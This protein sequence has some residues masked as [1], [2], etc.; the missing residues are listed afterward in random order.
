MPQELARVNR[1]VSFRAARAM[2]SGS[3]STS[4]AERSAMSRPSLNTSAPGGVYS[5]IRCMSWVIISTVTPCRFSPRKNSM[6]SV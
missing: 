2:S 6:I 4:A 1:L 5:N 3:H